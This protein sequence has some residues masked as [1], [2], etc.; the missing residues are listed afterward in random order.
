MGWEPD[1]VPDAQGFVIE[2]PIVCLT[3]KAPMQKPACLA[4]SAVF[5]FGIALAQTPEGPL[6]SF[7]YTPGLDVSAMDKSADPCMDFYRTRAADG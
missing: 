6:T 7:P 5:S 2:S 1:R 3:R 4:I